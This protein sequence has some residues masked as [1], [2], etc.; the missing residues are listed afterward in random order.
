MQDESLV[1]ATK[2]AITKITT[3]YHGHTGI[4]WVALLDTIDLPDPDNLKRQ[5]DG[6]LNVYENPMLYIE[7]LERKFP[8]LTLLLESLS[9]VKY[10]EEDW[11]RRL[12]EG[13]FNLIDFNENGSPCFYFGDNYEKQNGKITDQVKV[14]E[15]LRG[16]TGTKFSTAAQIFLYYDNDL[17]PELGQ[18][19]EGALLA[20][21]ESQYKI[22]KTVLETTTKF[23]EILALLQQIISNA[24]LESISLITT[25]EDGQV[26]EI[27]LKTLS[28]KLVLLHELGIIE[29]LKSRARND[30]PGFSDGS[31]AKILAGLLG[32]ENQCET[33]RKGVSGYGHGKKSDIR[34]DRALNSVKGQLLKFGIKI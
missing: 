28:E 7:S 32:V 29:H 31:L 3:N 24:K 30:V 11:M 33:I 15:Y 20:K 23:I 27:E 34:T 26:S 14:N 19:T 16:S 2:R 9:E 17:F 13:V 6:I 18:V 8:N 21:L 22:H 5:I 1:Y 4:S 10:K 25:L 12:Q